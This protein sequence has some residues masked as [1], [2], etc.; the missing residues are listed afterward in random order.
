MINGENKNGLKGQHNLAQGKRSVAL[1]WGK[2]FEFVRGKK[3]N[4]ESP[5]CRTKWSKVNFLAENLFNS[6]RKDFFALF[7]EFT[8]TFFS[9][10]SYT[11]GGSRFLPGLPWAMIF[12]TFSPEKHPVLT[13]SKREAPIEII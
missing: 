8:R 9:S 10:A 6:V 7:M 3:Q 13:M 1:G 11:Q 4:N 12:W 2:V 5:Y